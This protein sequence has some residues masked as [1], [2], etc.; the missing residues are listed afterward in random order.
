MGF[1]NN[2]F[3]FGEK[4]YIYR[5]FNNKEGSIAWIRVFHVIDNRGYGLS[6]FAFEP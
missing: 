6:N 1:L 3:Y 5:C 4:T 2:P